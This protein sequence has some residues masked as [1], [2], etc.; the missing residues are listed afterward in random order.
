MCY[1]AKDGVNIS[2]LIEKVIVENVYKEDYEKITEK[3]LFKIVSY[4][5]NSYSLGDKQI[6]NSNY[7]LYYGEKCDIV[8]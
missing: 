5:E 2:Q 1:S 6:F 3:L 8:I 4:D 7:H